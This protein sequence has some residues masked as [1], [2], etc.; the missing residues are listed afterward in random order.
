MTDKE[1]ED[2]VAGDVKQEDEEDDLG[3]EKNQPLYKQ[4]EYD[5]GAEANRV[6]DVED[7]DVDHG[8]EAEEE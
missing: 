4:K 3:T 7:E 6:V 5:P 2:Q 1:A 8:T